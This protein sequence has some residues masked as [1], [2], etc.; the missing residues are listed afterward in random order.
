VPGRRWHKSQRYEE[1][2]ADSR[3]DLK[4]GHYKVA[5]KPKHPTLV[6]VGVGF[7]IGGD[8]SGEGAVDVGEIAG[9]EN[10]ADD[11]PD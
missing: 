1:R 8:L 7:G 10:H 3:A 2:L 11:P 4:I 9:G 6:A 5:E